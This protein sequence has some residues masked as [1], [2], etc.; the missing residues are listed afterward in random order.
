MTIGSSVTSIGDSA[1]SFCAS[2]ANITIPSSVTSIGDHAFAGCTVV[3]GVYFQGN[4]PNPG[5][6]CIWRGISYVTVYYLPGVHRLGRALGLTTRL[7]IFQPCCGMHRSSPGQRLE[8]PINLDSGITG[9]SNLRRRDR[10]ER[11][12]RATRWAGFLL[13]TPS[14][15]A[16]L[17][18]LSP[19][20]SGPT[21][22]SRFYRVTWP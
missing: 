14:P 19:T 21:I 16:A 2:L 10:G 20:R 18:F 5:L 6:K 11:Q 4:A 17:H 15:S 7:A 12:S 22:P 3:R 13:E 1:F 8:G 9:S